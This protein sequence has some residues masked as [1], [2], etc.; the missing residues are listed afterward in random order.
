ME[1][2]IKIDVAS[3]QHTKLLDMLRDRRKLAINK[4]NELKVDWE[5]AERTF[6]AYTDLNPD[7]YKRQ[8]N[9]ERG[10]KQDYVTITV[11][12]STALLMTAYTYWASVFFG[13][14]PIMQ[15]VS[16]SGEQ[17]N[18][19]LALESLLNYQVTIGDNLPVL[20]IWLLDIGKYG[21]GVMNVHWAQQRKRI[22]KQQAKPPKAV[23]GVVVNPDAP[24]KTELVRGFMP[25]YTGNKLTNV[26]PQNFL[27]DP[28]VPITRFQ[29]G[30]FCGHLTM[31][32]PNT[33]L[34]GSASG[35][36]FN[37]K[38]ALSRAGNSGERDFSNDG[39]Q[40]VVMPA[41]DDISSSVIEV[42]KGKDGKNTGQFIELMEMTVEIVPQDYELADES[43]GR[44]PEKWVFTVADGRVI[45]GARPLG[46]YHDK[47]PYIVQEYELDGY[48][49]SSRGILKILAPLNYTMSWLI[50]SHF[51]NVRAILNG[52]IIVDPSRIQMSDLERKTTGRVIRLSP[53]GYGT[54]AK[55]AIHQFPGVDVTQNNMRDVQVVEM[56]MQRVIG[57]NDSIMGMLGGGSD[58]KTATEVRTS[59]TFGV[60]RLKTNVEYFSAGGFSQLIRMMISNA[61]QYY[62]GEQKL[63]IAGEQ[64]Q[65]Q[66]FVEVTP[67]SIAGEFDYLPVDGTLPIDRFAQ[68]TLW[69]EMLAGMMQN[70]NLATQYDVAGIFAWIAQLAGLKNIKSFRVNVLPPGA[71]PPE[72]M[73]DVRKVMAEQQAG[74]ANENP[75][76]PDLATAPVGQVGAVG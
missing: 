27:P 15:L 45:V 11:P 7:E 70:E 22:V 38:A 75:Q 50:N 39:V 14:D 16:I 40:E 23:A 9:N 34:R 6:R 18:N 73:Q 69:R 19:V 33:L 30:E 44:Y 35:E 4:N 65:T 53:S 13:R 46:C 26:R 37:V 57:A 21:R 60:N 10:A 42:A 52:T 72:G 29:E 58:R 67:E 17:E 43:E 8:Q 47:F 54:D 49:L 64:S 36:F 59:S 71:I 51:A 74:S 63:R 68:A 1:F 24:P 25:G 5:H 76:G 28:R 56:L 31:V 62:T 2:P 55:A 20:H 66:Q 32:S 12:Y 3:E 41:V 48:T 61:Q